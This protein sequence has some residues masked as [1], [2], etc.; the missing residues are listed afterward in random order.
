MPCVAIVDGIETHDDKLQ[1]ERQTD[2]GPIS[3]PK[4]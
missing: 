1:F 3:E 4:F 2:T